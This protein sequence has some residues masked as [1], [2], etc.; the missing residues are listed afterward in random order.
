MAAVLPVPGVDAITGWEIAP[1]RV[2]NDL[3]LA[4]CS[5]IIS[6][7]DKIDSFAGGSFVSSHRGGVD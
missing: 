7:F 3:T 6:Y 2:R 1:V 5:Q 4:T